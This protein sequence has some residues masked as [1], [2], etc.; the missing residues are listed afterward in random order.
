MSNYVE[1]KEK[2]L[3]EEPVHKRMSIKKVHIPSKGLIDINGKVF[4]AESDFLSEITQQIGISDTSIKQLRKNLD[5]DEVHAILNKS[6]SNYFKR[7]NPI[8]GNI[9]GKK[10]S[11]SLFR[12]SK[13]DVIPY[14]TIFGA[15]EK[16]KNKFEEVKLDVYPTEVRILLNESKKIEMPNLS[17]E[18]FA[19]NIG[20]AYSYARSFNLE[21]VIERLSCTNQ[22]RL[23]VQ[24]N[25]EQNLSGINSPYAIMQ[26]LAQ[27]QSTRLNE[28][29][30]ERVNGISNVQASLKEYEKVSRLL[31]KYI[32]KDNDYLLNGFLKKAE[33]EKFITREQ[34]L[35]EGNLQSKDKTFL[36]IFYWDLINA[37]TDFASHDYQILRL[38]E[39]EI[40][41]HK[42]YQML[43]QIPDAQKF[44]MN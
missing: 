13:G 28:Q 8:Q 20:I 38:D 5:N 36:P 19:P 42:A 43:K 24:N 29:Y 1:L 30:I 14:K 35:E 12:L 9:I 4:K 37:I 33:I 31:T 21:K 23:N 39:R 32:G 26:S 41:Q 27:M 15:V 40:L 18:A 22:I 44:S 7:H 34:I 11:T 16:V 6:F 10:E 17:K 2:A 3:L 25:P